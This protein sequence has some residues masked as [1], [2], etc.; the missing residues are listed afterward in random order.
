MKP[1]KN[2]NQ[3]RDFGLIIG[4]SFPILIGFIFPYFFGHQFRYWTLL[5]GLPLII[6]AL[7]APK[8]L[9]FFYDRWI[10]IGNLLGFVNSKIIL[11][12]I[13][14]LLVQPI[15]L[16]MK[17]FGYD[18]LRRKSKFLLSYREVRKNDKINLEKIF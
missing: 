16:I 5:I 4:I 17:I 7:I 13:F 18:P 1:A 14:I 8:N 3:L 10:Q 12:L 9:N 11:A 15:S 6:I 2:K